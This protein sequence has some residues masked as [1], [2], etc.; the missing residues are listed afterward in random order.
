MCNIDPSGTSETNPEAT[1][2]SPATTPVPT[3]KE[4]VPSDKPLTSKEAYELFRNGKL[5]LMWA[6]SSITEE[7]FCS[8]FLDRSP[9]TPAAIRTLDG[10]KLRYHP[11]LRKWLIT[12][13][14]EAGK[15]LDNAATQ[16]VKKKCFTMEAEDDEERKKLIDLRPDHSSPAKDDGE[17][18]TICEVQFSP[19]S[20]FLTK[21]RQQVISKITGEPV[22]I[23]NYKIIGVN[24]DGEIVQT[25][26]QS[27]V[28]PFCKDCSRDVGGESYTYE[29]AMKAIEEAE[30][31]KETEQNRANKAVML[32]KALRRPD[33]SSRFDSGDAHEDVD[34]AARILEARRA[35]GNFQGGNRRHR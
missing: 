12:H 5:N 22:R 34:Q 21:D 8:Q 35:K 25:G 4:W 3:K 24:K 31:Q 13:A 17:T 15:Q 26:G 33:G 9:V 27:T 18:C 28:M 10:Q 14:K 30:A 7:A 6:P 20:L 1:D 32:R 29:N 16:E 23:G 11:K 19:M 2:A